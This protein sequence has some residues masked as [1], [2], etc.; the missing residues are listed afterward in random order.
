[1]NSE[2]VLSKVEWKVVIGEG[3]EEKGDFSEVNRVG[4][5]QKKNA[6]W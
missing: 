5:E 1:M 6:S 4:V 3:V 2:E